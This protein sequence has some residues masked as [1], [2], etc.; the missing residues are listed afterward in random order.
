MITISMEAEEVFVPEQLKKNEIKVSKL[1]LQQ[2]KLKEKSIIFIIHIFYV[3]VGVL[4]FKLNLHGYDYM[5]GRVTKCT[6]K[7]YYSIIL[8]QKHKI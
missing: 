5:R 1:S 2:K 3:F 4:N 6:V 8:L 7:H